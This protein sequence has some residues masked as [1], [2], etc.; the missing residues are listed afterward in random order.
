MGLAENIPGLNLHGSEPVPRSFDRAEAG[1]VVD[2]LAAELNACPVGFTA[3][4][5]AEVGEEYDQLLNAWKR[6]LASEVEKD[7]PLFKRECSTMQALL[8]QWLL[9]FA[10]RGEGSQ[11][12]LFEAGR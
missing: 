10:E 5:Q 3:W 4:L 2:V 12:G 8:R 1:R 7:M 11:A 9:A 6:I